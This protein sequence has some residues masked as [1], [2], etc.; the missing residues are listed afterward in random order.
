MTYS[1]PVVLDQG[2]VVARTLGIN[3]VQSL[4]SATLFRHPTNVETAAGSES[5][6]GKTPGESINSMSNE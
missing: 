2:S 6:D 5:T 4:E 1:T 3:N